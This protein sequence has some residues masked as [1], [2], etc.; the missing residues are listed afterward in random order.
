MDRKQVLKKAAELV[1]NDRQRT[2]GDA[3]ESHSRIADFWSAYLGVKIDAVDAAAM[4]VL[5]KI[6][7]TVGSRRAG[8]AH[9]DSWIDVCG[10]SSLASELESRL[11]RPQSDE[12]RFDRGEHGKR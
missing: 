6:S 3:L 8:V 1:S 2:Y 7:R 11:N 5:L 10:Y 4:M 12:S 9:D